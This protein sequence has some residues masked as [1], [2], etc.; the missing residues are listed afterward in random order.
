MIQESDED[1]KDEDDDSLLDR[2]M[3]EGTKKPFLHKFG[4][5]EQTRLQ[6]L[7]SEKLDLASESSHEGN[8]KGV[9][10]TLYTKEQQS[11]S[12]FREPSVWIRDD[13]WNVLTNTRANA[14][15]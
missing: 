1:D 2:T 14:R 3:S 7:S 12:A 4:A 8:S 11:S 10:D 9:G 5:S 15:G 13:F 6:G